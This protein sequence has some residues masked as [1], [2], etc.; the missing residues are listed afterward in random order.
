MIINKRIEL[1]RFALMHCIA[2][3]LC[4]W[5]WTILRETMDSFTH[6]SIQAKD[7]NER[8][9]AELDSEN[10]LQ[11]Y[12]LSLTSY[13]KQGAKELVKFLNGTSTR[14]GTT[15]KHDSRMNIIYEN[16]SPYLYPFTVEYSILVGK[17][18]VIKL[19]WNKSTKIIV[20]R[21]IFN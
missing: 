3:S 1:A 15:C 9:T 2:S 17:W 21:Y 6:H 14:V 7:S 12:A 10:N 11:P 8:I 4:F 13:T 5:V 20:K 16:Y 19:R 18:T